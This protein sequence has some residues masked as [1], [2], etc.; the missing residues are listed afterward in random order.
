MIDTEA[1]APDVLRADL[2]PPGFALAE[3]G[4][5]TPES[6]RGLLIYAGRRFAR[7]A[8]ARYGFSLTFYSLNWVSQVATTRPH[9]DGGPDG[10]LLLLGYEPSV[11]SSRFFVMDHSRAAKERGMSPREFLERYSPTFGEGAKLL[12]PHTHAVTGFDPSRW[13][14]LAVN[15]SCL[16]GQGLL[17]VMH[18]AVIDRVPPGAIRPIVSVQ[19][20]VAGRGLSDEQLTAF[21][22]A[23]SA[24]IAEEG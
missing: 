16:D 1:I 13:Q 6:L 11:V 4:S 21:I 18:H 24:A 2:S 5:Q 20:G 17:G 10:S 9:R 12:E 23:G 14:V 22:R 7:W 8:E 19:L 3:V 15:N